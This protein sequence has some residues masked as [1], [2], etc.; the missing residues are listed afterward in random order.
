MANIILS[1]KFKDK[2]FCLCATTTKPY[3]RHYENAPELINP[4]FEC[5][6]DKNQL[7]IDPTQDS[8]HNNTVLKLK[9]EAYQSI[10]EKHNPT[11]GKEMFEIFHSGSKVVAKEELTI[12]EYL[13]SIIKEMRNTR[14]NAP[15][16]NY[17]KYI[18]LLHKMEKEGNIIHVP[19][20]EINNK[21]F[22]QFGAWVLSLTEKEGLY[23]YANI[24]KLFKQ[25][26]KKAYNKEL[27]DNILR[28]KYMDD[29][30]KR[31]SFKKKRV[32]LTIQKY[33]KFVE[34][35][36]SI[37]SKSGV[38]RMYYKELY[39]DFCIFLYEM[40]MRPV[41]VIKAHSDNIEFDGKTKYIVYRP[42]KKKNSDSIVYSPISPKA[43]DIIKKYKNKSSKGYIF[44]FSMNE[45]DWNFRN[46][47]SWNKWELRKSRTLEQINT[48]LGKVKEILKVSELTL[49]TFRHTIFTQEVNDNKKSLLQIAK[50]GGT[51]V[52]M[53]DKYYYKNAPNCHKVI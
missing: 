50:E 1:Y 36:L 5:W 14:T 4:N 33:E 16:K 26:H 18:G 52:E 41:D 21:H 46:A 43:E 30:P 51:S 7:F 35:D 32:P 37:I 27:N 24:M 6:D 40:K 23:N 44:P 19:L 10:I 48:F 3:Q 22:I 39:R 15:S 11:N 34:M 53:L 47:D 28:Y 45:Y 25:L 38:N 20:S 12:G 29:Q 9:K 31:M 8:V 2:R 17:Q 13:I 49:Y 42:E